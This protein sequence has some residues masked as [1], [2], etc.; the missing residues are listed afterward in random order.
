M[1]IPINAK[2]DIPDSKKGK[3]TPAQNAMVNSWT[4]SKKTGIFNIA[5]DFRCE[6][7]A[8]TPINNVVTVT[9]DRGF[10][11]VCG[12][13]VEVEQ[14]TTINITLPAIGSIDGNIV[15][16]FNL[17]ASQEGEFQV[18]A[19]TE[20]PITED[21]NENIT[22]RYDF[23][24]YGYEA[25]SNGVTLKARSNSV[26]I[27]D[28]G[29]TLSNLI[30]GLENGTNEVAKSKEAKN[31]NA[32]EGTIK[33]KFDAIETRLTD[34]GFKTGSVSGLA[35]ATLN[36][37]GKY[38]I[39]NLPA[40]GVSGTANNDTITMT[41]SCTSATTFD[42]VLAGDTESTS[43]NRYVRVKVSFTAMSKEIIITNLG[44]S[45]AKT[46]PSQIGFEISAW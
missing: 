17:S 36:K 8:S 43:G 24:L 20:T 45:Y 14:G 27:D 19:T 3:L 42:V 21:L 22:G 32:T 46:T 1:F 28:V 44:T 18:L 29:N 25:K 5:E 13:L 16:R 41:M 15:A 10:F 34:L 7:E 37:M 35:G 4:L 26:Y 6:A 11:V 12:R 40:F 39:L 23:V 33:T 31:Y 30:R 2:A 38:A 9:F